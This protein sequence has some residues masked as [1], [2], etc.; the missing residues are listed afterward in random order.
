MKI[1][2]VENYDEMSSMAASYVVRQVN[3]KPDSVL[4]LA[5]GNTPLGMYRDLI[6][7]YHKGEIDFSGTTMFSLDE[8]CNL[9]K[10]NPQSY[11]YFMNENLISD[12]NVKAENTFIPNGMAR[13]IEAE[14]RRYDRKI[15]EKGGI[16]LQVL[17]IGQNGHIGFNEPG[18]DFETETHL[19]HL[20]KSTVDTNASHFNSREEVPTSAISMG[21]KTIMQSRMVILMASGKKKADAIRKAIKGE[22]TSSLPASILQ[23]HPNVVFIIDENAAS[24]L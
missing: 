8:Y 5:A 10:D 11:Y 23:T 21:I 3:T 22:I 7:A 17:G 6:K 14:C 12:I 1:I 2:I 18:S 24:S 16:D 19:V 13:D 4:G 15:L 20:K 9:D